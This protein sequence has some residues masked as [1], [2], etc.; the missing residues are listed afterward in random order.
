MSRRFSYFAIIVFTAAS[1]CLQAQA[2]QTFDSPEAAAKAL[3]DAAAQDDAARLASLLGAEGKSILTSGDPAQDKAER[4]EFARIARSKYELQRDSMDSDRMILSIGSED[5]PFPV[6]IVKMK[7][8]WSFDASMGALVM[9][10]RT[11]GANELDVIEACSA[12]VSAQQE[13]AQRTPAK[14]ALPQYARHI[15]STSAARPDG[16]YTDSEGQSLAPQDFA[17]AAVEGQNAAPPVPYHGYLFRV[18]TGQGPNAPEGQH[19]YLVKDS[20]AGGFGL[21]AWP[22]Q[23]GVTGIHTFIVNQDG[24]VYQKDMGAQ[25]SPTAIIRYDPDKSWKPVN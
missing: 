15:R 16:L 5:W 11:I 3:I 23:Y 4:A 6:P 7:G 21:V 2:P 19:S 18:L 9:S 10:A 22:A 13:Y 12:Y 25:A 17:E 24:I 20:L 1:A 14:G 8:K